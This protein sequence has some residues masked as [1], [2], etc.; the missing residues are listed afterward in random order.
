MFY[1]RGWT[2]FKAGVHF[3]KVLDEKMVLRA[4]ATSRLPKVKFFI[5]LFFYFFIFGSIRVYI[6]VPTPPP[7]FNAAGQL[8]SSYDE[9][10]TYPL[11]GS[12]HLVVPCEVLL[13][14]SIS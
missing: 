8:S 1:S 2:V 5:F 11:Q 7:L 13:S 4:L 9:L 10:P 6:Y 14:R 3:R 12:S